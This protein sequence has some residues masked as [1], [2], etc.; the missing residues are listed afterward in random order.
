M[1]SILLLY[2]VGVGVVAV[3][4][5]G[6]YLLRDRYRYRGAPGK[7]EAFRATGEVFRDPASGRLTRVYEDPATGRRQ[8]REEDG[9]GTAG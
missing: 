5:V 6:G 1:T 9:P 4:A 2:A 3:V 7:G 8:Y